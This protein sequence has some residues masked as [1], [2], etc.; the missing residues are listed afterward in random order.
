MRWWGLALAGVVLSACTTTSTIVEKVAVA[1]ATTTTTIDVH[2][3]GQKVMSILSTG[4]AEIT[5]DKAISDN[6]TS[7]DDI[8]KAFSSTA[9]A[10]QSLAYPANAQ[11][12][13]KALDAA[14]VKLSED[15]SIIAGASDLSMLQASENS[16]VSDEGTEEAD[17]DALRHDLGLPPAS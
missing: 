15:A 3:L 12:D 14:L 7:F 17:S 11:S 16:M 9:Q 13:A 4:N 1:P 2:A 8:S 5:Q 10:L 6:T